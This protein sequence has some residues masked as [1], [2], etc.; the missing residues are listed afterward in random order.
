MDVGSIEQGKQMEIIFQQVTGSKLPTYPLEDSG[1]W[2]DAF[3]SG[4]VI[5]VKSEQ[6]GQGVD[7]AS[8][9]EEAKVSLMRK[10]RAG[11]SLCVGCSIA[12][13]LARSQE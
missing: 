10:S 1:K 12:P 11:E 9:L 7:P 4:C 8:F 2:K 13:C 6:L 3:P 5:V